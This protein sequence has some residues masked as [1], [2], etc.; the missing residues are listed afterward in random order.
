[1]RV[2]VVALKLFQGTVDGKALDSGKVF[3]EVNL[4]STRNSETQ[5]GAGTVTEELRLPSA[6][7]VRR[8]KHLPLPFMADLDVQRV[9]NGKV[10]KE[11]VMDIRPIDL[12]KPAQVARAA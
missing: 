8:I 4:D 5:F 12:A 3:V 7:H 1:M 6:E 2:K 11:V 9:S 10:S